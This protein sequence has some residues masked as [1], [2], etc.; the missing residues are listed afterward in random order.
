[1]LNKSTSMQKRHRVPPSRH[2]HGEDAA[3]SPSTLARHILKSIA[4]SLLTAIL[5]LMVLSMAAYFTGDPA[6]LLLPLGLVAAAITALVGGFTAV[7]LHKKN[8]LLCGLA[9]GSAMMAIM[10]L[11]SLFFKDGA[12]AHSPLLSCLLHAAFLVLSIL[13]AFA[14]LPRTG[15]KKSKRPSRH[16]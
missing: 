12:S 14:A 3:K 7:K 4:V 8:A 1:M 2:T 16:R 13:G 10:L 9:N 11:V 6:T 5:S 15:V